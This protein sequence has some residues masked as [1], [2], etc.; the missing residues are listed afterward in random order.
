MH[1]SLCTLQ[2]RCACPYENY[3]R[4]TWG[5]KKCL[6]VHT[7]DT[8]RL[9]KMM[10]LTAV[11]RKNFTLAVCGLSN[12]FV[13][14]CELCMY[15]LNAVTM[16]SFWYVYD[17]PV[18]TALVLTLIALWFSGPTHGHSHN[19]CVACAEP[20]WGRWHHVSLSALCSYW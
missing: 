4:T 15:T 10:R 11:P 2:H 20:T 5:Y 6:G 16:S 9:G 13:L 1:T 3:M 18:V 8:V 14:A 19:I 7:N 12:N 17:M